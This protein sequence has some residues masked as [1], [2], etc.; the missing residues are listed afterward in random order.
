V[1]ALIRAHHPY[2][3]PEVVALEVTRGLPDYL[4]WIAGETQKKETA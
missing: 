1:E 3:L 4:A 2:E